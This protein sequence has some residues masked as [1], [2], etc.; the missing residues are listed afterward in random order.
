MDNYINE[1]SQS[2]LLNDADDLESSRSRNTPVAKL[3]RDKEADGT[4][5]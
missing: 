5:V 4:G 2:C 3:L 1:I